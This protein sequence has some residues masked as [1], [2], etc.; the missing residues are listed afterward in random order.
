MRVPFLGAPHREAA[1]GLPM[2]WRLPE[3][4]EEKAALR[5]AADL[6]KLPKDIV[7]RPKLPAG[8]ATAPNLLR[9]ALSEHHDAAASVA[10]RYPR[11]KASLTHQPDVMLGLALFEAVH[12]VDGGRAAPTGS[13]ADLLEVV[14]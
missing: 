14:A 12:L 8:T 11:L 6:T 13:V 7:R 5:R 1:H 10:E 4:G 9:E 3:S 2:T